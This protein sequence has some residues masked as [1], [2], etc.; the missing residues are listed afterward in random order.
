M[1]SITSI[2]ARTAS[3]DEWRGLRSDLVRL[4]CFTLADCLPHE[5]V[6]EV[7][8]ALVTLFSVSP[9]TKQACLV[10]KRVHRLAAGYSPF[11]VATALDTGVPNLLETW[12]I[13][14]NGTNWPTE[15]ASEWRVL[16][17][18][19]RLLAEA[20]ISGLEIVAASLGVE[21]EELTNLVDAHSIEGI[22]LIHYFPVP[23]SAEPQAR[24]QSMHCDN[25]LITLIPPPHPIDSGLDVFNRSVNAW[26]HVTTGANDCLVQAGLILERITSAA[27]RANLH[28]VK[29][30]EYG[31]RENTSRY[32][33]PFFRS[34]KPGTV[35]SVLEKFKTQCSAPD[36][37]LESLEDDYF[38]RIF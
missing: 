17:K 6:R 30:P 22:H 24:R 37:S 21:N 4:G 13:S 26:E 33:T 12:D 34:P 38:K 5:L 16:R 23:K 20:T 9:E 27:I 15:L 25:T 19:Q 28:T 18:Y 29:T 3:R 36:V 31:S 1:K 32:A 10:D 14:P 7:H 11:G 35:V 8:L 2:R